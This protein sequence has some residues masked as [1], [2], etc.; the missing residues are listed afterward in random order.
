MGTTVALDF[1]DYLQGRNQIKVRHR[2]D[3]GT[4]L[5]NGKEAERMVN[6]SGDVAEVLNDYIKLPRADVTD[7]YGREPLFTT[8]CGR[9][10]Q[11]AQARRY[12]MFR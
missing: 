6:I 1:E 11:Q 2:P 5:K 9:L 8:R 4:P 10:F 12:S 7:D 3:T